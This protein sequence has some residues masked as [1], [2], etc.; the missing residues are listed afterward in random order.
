MFEQI[1]G[2]LHGAFPR[3]VL[4]R[5]HQYLAVPRCQWQG[6]IVGVGVQAIADGDIHRIAEQIGDLVGEEEAQVQ[7]GMLSAKRREPGQQ[8]VA[9]QIGG[10]GH[11]QRSAELGAFLTQVVA[12]V[13]EGFQG[14]KGRGQVPLAFG[15]QAQAARGAGKQSHIQLTLQ[16]LDCFGRLAG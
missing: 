14:D 6:Y 8:H 12:P 16:A 5:G 10:R 1:F 9:P 2:G 3:Q 11:L 15:C 13:P 4:G 7:L